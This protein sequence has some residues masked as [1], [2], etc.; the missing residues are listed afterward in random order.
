VVEDIAVRFELAR[1]IM[2]AGDAALPRSAAAEET[3]TGRRTLQ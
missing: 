3:P 1:V 2:D